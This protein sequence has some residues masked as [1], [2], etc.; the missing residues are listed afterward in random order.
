M[1]ASQ[2]VVGQCAHC[3]GNASLNC[4]GCLRA[5]E[6]EIGD[7]KQTK[8]CGREC[9]TAHWPSH[10]AYCSPMRKR[11]K[12]LR[13]A[14]LLKAVLLVYRECTFDL[15]IK[16]IALN[17]GVLQLHQNLRPASARR[18]YRQF[19]SE[20]ANSLEQKEAVLANNQCTTALALFGSLAKKLLSNFTSSIETFDLHIKSPAV[21]T[22]LVPGPD[23]AVCPHSVL[24]VGLGSESWV[25]DPAGC[26]YG[27]REVLVPYNKYLR[28]KQGTITAEP[29][30]YSWTETKDLDFFE[31][32]PFMNT[33][34]AQRAD[35][36]EERRIRLH[37]ASFVEERFGI[38]QQQPGAV[39]GLLEC[40]PEDFGG[41]LGGLM[42]DLRKHM[43]SYMEKHGLYK[44]R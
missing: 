20:L 44:Q 26:Q 13:A 37:Y 12:L 14:R 4:S 9:Q 27:F 25:L 29:E 23:S 38:R 40:K 32:L 24:K 42:E 10:K 30:P 28:G 33:T 19:P 34:T 18:Q 7:V 1:A 41:Q 8:Y 21:R 17:D 22:Q 16:R 35:R 11:Q 43:M 5:P 15:D 2:D 36:A 3:G 31:T 39:K 6:Y